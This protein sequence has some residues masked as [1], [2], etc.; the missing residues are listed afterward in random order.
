MK[1]YVLAKFK[2]DGIIKKCIV[3]TWHTRISILDSI[4]NTNCVR[5]PVTVQQY[6]DNK[7][8]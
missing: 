6:V 1:F 2:Y 5:P 3:P 7:I 4:F 8:N